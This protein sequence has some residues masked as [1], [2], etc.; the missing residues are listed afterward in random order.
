MGLG[1]PF[2][3]LCVV[4]GDTGRTDLEVKMLGEEIPGY[5]LGI[6]PFSYR[7]MGAGA[8]L[9][10]RRGMVYLSIQPSYAARQVELS[11]LS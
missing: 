4:G 6:D 1:H 3:H 5:P 9:A 2:R 11:F 8:W 10:G 7:L